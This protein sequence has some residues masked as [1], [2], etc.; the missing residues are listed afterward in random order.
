MKFETIKTNAKNLFAGAFASDWNRSADTPPC[1]LTK[2]S[3]ASFEA[4]LPFILSSQAQRDEMREF[5]LQ[6]K[7]REGDLLAANATSDGKDSAWNQVLLRAR[8]AGLQL[9]DNWDVRQV[10]KLIELFPG[11]VPAKYRA[12]QLTCY[13]ADNEN[14]DWMVEVA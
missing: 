3:P 7:A 5:A 13:M 12:K 1:P 14:C 8:E 6:F 11:C 9:I 4:V 10:G 2:G